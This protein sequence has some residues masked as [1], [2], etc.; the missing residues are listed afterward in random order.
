MEMENRLAISRSRAKISDQSRY[1]NVL[2]VQVG[3]CKQTS[4]AGKSV[5]SKKKRLLKIYIV[6]VAPSGTF[7]N[8][9]LQIISRRLLMTSQH[10]LRQ[11]KIK[12]IK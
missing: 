2:P 8:K 9:V 4:N 3:C 1:N 11:S 6:E 5:K 7:D 10:K 12:K